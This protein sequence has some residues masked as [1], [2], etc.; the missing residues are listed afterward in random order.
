L[1]AYLFLCGGTSSHTCEPANTDPEQKKKRQCSAEAR[2]E[3][4][5][6]KL[7]HDIFIK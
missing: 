2:S 7:I 6:E 1:N 5:F 4:E 3:E